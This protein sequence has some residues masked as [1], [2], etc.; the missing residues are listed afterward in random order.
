[1]A[2]NDQENFGSLLSLV[3]N[4]ME[5]IEK[6]ILEIAQQQGENSLVFHR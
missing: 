4:N 3:K 1:L 6:Y 2:G 5:T